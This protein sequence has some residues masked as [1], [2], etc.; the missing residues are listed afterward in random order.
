MSKRRISIL[1]TGGTI[2]A[3]GADATATTIYAID[4]ARNP[5]ADL[6]ASLGPVADVRLEPFCHTPSHDLALDTVL[7]LAR[8]VEALLAAGEADGIVVTHGTDTLEET[9]FVLDL[10]LAPAGPVILTG[11]ARPSSALS[12]DGPLNLLNAVRVAASPDAAGRGI[13]TCLNDRIGAA[14]FIA[15][16]HTSAPDAFRANEQGYLGAVTGAEVSFFSPSPARRAAWF[17]LDAI[18]ALP[19]VAIVYG[20]L[21]MDARMMELA[22][23][24]GASGI[25]VAATGNGSMP[26]AIKPALARA[27]EA[28]LVVV[29]AS[30]VGSGAVSTAPVDTEYGTLPAGWLNPQKA[31]LLLM[32]ALGQGADRDRVAA[33]FRAIAH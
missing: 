21:G 5:V 18:G 3:S 6:M 11:A 27:R 19:R 13:L 20:H 8:R 25:V 12:A 33:H 28:G 10:V 4:P 16:V 30:R 24:D 2:A 14:R 26:A 23:E 31:R 22:I 17:R 32:I 9:A 29:R 1:T 15:K 7:A